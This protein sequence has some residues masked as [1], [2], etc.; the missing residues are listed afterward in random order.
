[1]NLVAKAVVISLLASTLF[2]TVNAEAK[3]KKHATKK[4]EKTE[5]QESYCSIKDDDHEIVYIC[6]DHPY[7]PKEDAGEG[8]VGKVSRKDGDEW[9]M[10]WDVVCGKWHH[11]GHVSYKGT[12]KADGSPLWSK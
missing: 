2:T 11:I 7:L 10:S 4:A 5:V 12:G 8:C 6:E 3:G 9:S 1:M